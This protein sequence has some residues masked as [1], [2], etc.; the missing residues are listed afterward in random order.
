MKVSKGNGGRDIW[1]VNPDNCQQ[2]LPNLHVN[3]GM[4][5]YHGMTKLEAPLSRPLV[6]IVSLTVFNVTSSL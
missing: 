3:E 1:I 5:V 4:L 6:H 2:V